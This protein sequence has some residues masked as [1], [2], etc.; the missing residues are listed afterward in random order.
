SVNEDEI[1]ISSSDV[2]YEEE[3]FEDDREVENLLEDRPT[4]EGLEDDEE[5]IDERLDKNAFDTE[6]ESNRKDFS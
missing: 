1:D 5:I 4:G 2:E 3:E 6:G